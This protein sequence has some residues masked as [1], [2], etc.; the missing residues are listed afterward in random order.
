MLSPDSA[1]LA[2]KPEEGADEH[3][4]FRTQVVDL[5]ER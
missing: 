1:R 4:R 3:L 2:L 5:L